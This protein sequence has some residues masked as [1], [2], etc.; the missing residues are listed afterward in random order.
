MINI[1]VKITGINDVVKRLQQFGAEATQ[2]T[3]RAINDTATHTRAEAVRRIREDWNVKAGTVREAFS[4]R[5]A[6]RD[7]LVA[8]VSASAQPIGLIHFGARQTRTGVSY[9]L[10]K[11]GRNTLKHAFIATMGSGHRGVF[12]RRT[13]KRLPIIEKASIS[14]P[15]MWRQKLDEQLPEASAFLR[16][17]VQ[18]LLR[19]AAEGK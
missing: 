11:F 15:S 12:L 19:R 8:E 13:K 4:I 7:R 1:G 16:K 6:T 5:K 10:K 9:K 3:V 14:T 18:Q 17:R 2:L